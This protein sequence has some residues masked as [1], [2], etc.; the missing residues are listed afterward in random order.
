MLWKSALLVITP[1]LLP[2]HNRSQHIAAHAQIRGSDMG[3][4]EASMVDFLKP[5]SNARELKTPCMIH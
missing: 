5:G 4:R 1:I 2:S 3:K